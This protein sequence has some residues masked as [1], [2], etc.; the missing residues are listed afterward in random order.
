MTPP[1][2]LRHPTWADLIVRGSFTQD[3][4]TLTPSPIIKLSTDVSCTRCSFTAYK[5]DAEALVRYTRLLF[6]A[7]SS[8]AG[9]AYPLTC[10]VSSA[11]VLLSQANY[12]SHALPGTG[13]DTLLRTTADTLHAEIRELRDLILAQSHEIGNLA[14]RLDAPNGATQQPGLVLEDM[15]SSGTQWC[16]ATTWTRLG[17]HG[18]VCHEL[19]YIYPIL[20]ISYCLDSLPTIPCLTN[21]HVGCFLP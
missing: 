9:D 10:H 6:I 1:A 17:R 11:Q 7:L 20:G 19:N 18:V 12:A 21:D 8:W 16:H 2:H 3:D 14:S 5:A 15:A 13:H 4:H